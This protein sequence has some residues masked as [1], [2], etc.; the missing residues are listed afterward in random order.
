MPNFL[1][2]VCMMGGGRDVFVFVCVCVNVQNCFLGITTQYL[3]SFILNS[4][5]SLNPWDGHLPKVF[6]TLR[7]LLH[8]VILGKS[9]PTEPV[10]TQTYYKYYLPDISSELDNLPASDNTEL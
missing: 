2:S 6:C 3:Y 8:S 4:D 9:K 5:P 1:L 10:L 7:E